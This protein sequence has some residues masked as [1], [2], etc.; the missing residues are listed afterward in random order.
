MKKYIIPWKDLLITITVTFF[1]VV[2]TGFNSAN[3]ALWVLLIYLVSLFVINMYR[4]MNIRHDSRIAKKRNRFYRKHGKIPNDSLKKIPSK[5]RTWNLSDDDYIFLFEIL[6]LFIG[7]YATSILACINFIRH[8]RGL[9]YDP[10]IACFSVNAFLLPMILVII[11]VF[12][13]HQNARQALREF[14]G[15]IFYKDGKL[16]IVRGLLVLFSSLL[17]VVMAVFYTWSGIAT[18]KYGTAW[19]VVSSTAA[20]FYL[21]YL[22]HGA[23]KT[24]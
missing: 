5:Y 2:I 3:D 20:L 17:L 21:L 18:S 15:S 10:F 9:E 13:D 1:S 24:A 8:T 14:F 19:M 7:L 23:I 11:S 16:H 4:Q 22:F 12:M 6:K